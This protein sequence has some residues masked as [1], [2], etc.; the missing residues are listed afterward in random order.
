M[1]VLD[2]LVASGGSERSSRE[3]D[4]LVG[5]VKHTV[6]ALQERI[7]IDEVK[8]V[9]ARETALCKGKTVRRNVKLEI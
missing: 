8:A 2:T 3:A 9:T 7:S 5:G 6:E 1:Q 4:T